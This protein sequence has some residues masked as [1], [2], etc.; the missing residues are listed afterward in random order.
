MELSLGYKPETL[1]GAL[2]LHKFIVITRLNYIQYSNQQTV[3]QP[4]AL[5]T[6]IDIICRKAENSQDT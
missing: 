1:R 3:N 2:S 4:V 6:V 5:C